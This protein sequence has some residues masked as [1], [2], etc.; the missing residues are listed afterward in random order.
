[1]FDLDVLLLF[2][3]L[4]DLF[5]VSGLEVGWSTGL[6]DWFHRHF[7]KSWL[8]KLFFGMNYLFSGVCLLILCCCGLLSTAESVFLWRSLLVVDSGSQILGVMD[9]VSR[10]KV[11]WLLKFI[12]WPQRM[13]VLLWLCELHDKIVLFY[14]HSVSFGIYFKILEQCECH[15]VFTS[16]NDGITVL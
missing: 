11:I 9:L 4:F 15:S 7:S 13:T 12:L 14:A 1:M 3:I 8:D 16:S 5:G 2:S 10:C 6:S